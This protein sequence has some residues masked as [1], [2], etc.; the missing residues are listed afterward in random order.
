MKPSPDDAAGVPVPPRAGGA[1]A[2]PSLSGTPGRREDPEMPLTP[3]TS[4]PPII[5]TDGEARLSN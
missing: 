2:A 5:E 4:A 3:A 1:P